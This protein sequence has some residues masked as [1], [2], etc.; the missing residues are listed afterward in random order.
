G[1]PYFVDGLG[2]A[3]IYAFGTPISGSQKRYNG[4]YGAML[5]KADDAQ[6]IFQFITRTGIVIDTYTLNKLA[7]P[8][9]TAL[10]TSTSSPMALVPEV[11]SIVH[12]MTNPTSAA[13]VD[14]TINFSKPVTGVDT[15]DFNLTPTGVI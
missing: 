7:I 8:T 1:I 15:S 5:I 3:S 12:A 11:L 4:D 6:I 13:S 2:G 14:F 9:S 10:S